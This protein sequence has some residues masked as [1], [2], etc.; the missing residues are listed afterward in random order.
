[1][2]SNEKMP[3]NDRKYAA[4]DISK[5]QKQTSKQEQQGHSGSSHN[6][7]PEKKGTYIKDMPEIIP[8]RTG[9]I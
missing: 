3:G 2:K 1:M 6:D 9:I 5:N 4:R 8:A 7:K